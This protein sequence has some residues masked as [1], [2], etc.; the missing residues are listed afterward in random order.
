MS[1]LN[2]YIYVYICIFV[3]D[4]GQSPI[5]VEILNIFKEQVLTNLRAAEL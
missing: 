5:V 4:E 2:K 1:N 3:C